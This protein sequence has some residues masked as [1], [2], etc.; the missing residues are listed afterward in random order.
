MKK[1]LWVVLAIFTLALV[2]R[3]GAQY[4]D[5]SPCSKEF[6]HG[7]MVQAIGQPVT[8]SAFPIRLILTEN[9]EGPELREAEDEFADVVNARND[10]KVAVKFMN[11][12]SYPAMFIVYWNLHRNDDGTF[13]LY[14]DVDGHNLPVQRDGEWTNSW[15][16][17]LFRN[18]YAG[19][20][21]D[22]IDRAI[23]DFPAFIYSGW[24]CN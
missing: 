17:H 6:S 3:A 16:G 14:E 11:D 8:G 5:D 4:H 12:L 1:L 23:S 2:P 13:S 22:V 24:T 7:F 15:N 20:A 19:K 9:V 10:H 18:Y 21:E